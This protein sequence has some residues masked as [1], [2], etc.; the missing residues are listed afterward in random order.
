[1][2]KQ[3]LECQQS[4]TKTLVPNHYDL[5]FSYLVSKGIVKPA[6]SSQLYQRVASWE[7]DSC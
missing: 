2:P 7:L 5:P 3:E 4:G 1:M 6:I